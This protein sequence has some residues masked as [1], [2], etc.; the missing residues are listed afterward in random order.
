[1]PP[2]I[3]GF[4]E[5]CF[6]NKR[7]AIGALALTAFAAVPCVNALAAEVPTATADNQDQREK[8]LVMLKLPAMV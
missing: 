1:V 8:K 2:V 4:Q 3:V 5:I 7:F 6:M